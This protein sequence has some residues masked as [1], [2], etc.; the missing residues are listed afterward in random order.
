ME[1]RYLQLFPEKEKEDRF[2]VKEVRNRL[3]SKQGC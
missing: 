2:K 3:W 1:Q